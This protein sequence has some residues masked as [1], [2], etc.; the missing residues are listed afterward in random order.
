MW[1]ALEP[2]GVL[3]VNIADVYGHHVWNQL[4]DPMND[5]I[6][7]LPNAEY[8]GGIGYRMAKRPNSLV[9]EWKLEGK[10]EKPDIGKVYVE[11]IWVWRKK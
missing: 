8:Q 2:N 6:A 7:T 5:F 9:D 11:P 1:D 3:A 4:C 10:T